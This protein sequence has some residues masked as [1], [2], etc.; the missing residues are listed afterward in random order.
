MFLG[1][2]IETAPLDQRS[3]AGW[4][5][6]LTAKILSNE[7]MVRIETGSTFSGAAN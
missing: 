3:T 5:G 7:Y 6:I 4:K 2:L 1:P